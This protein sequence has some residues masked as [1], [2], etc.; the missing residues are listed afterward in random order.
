MAQKGGIDIQSLS[1]E[2][3]SQLAK[4]VEQEIEY[5]LQNYRAVQSVISSYSEAREVLDELTPAN[6]GKEIFLPLTSS[7]YVPGT[8][9]NPEKVIVDVGTG[10]YMEKTVS[11]AQDY[12]ERKLA[13]LKK[14]SEDIEGSVESKRNSLA[15]I[16]MVLG[17]K[18]KARRNA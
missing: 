5:M 7:L 13:N 9:S 14:T 10:Y 12:T 1:P 2:Q 16:T 17:A 15:Q 4:Q 11:S 8:L 3:L 18:I 6:K